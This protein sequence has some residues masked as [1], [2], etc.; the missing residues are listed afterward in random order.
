M[1][2]VSCTLKAILLLHH[3]L[4][5]SICHTLSHF[6]SSLASHT[7]HRE[8]GSG[9]ATTIEL[10]PQQKLAVTEEICAVYRSHLLSRS[11]NYV[12]TCLADVSILLSNHAF[13]NCVPWR[14]LQHDQTLPLSVKGVACKTNFF[15]HGC[16]IRLCH[17]CY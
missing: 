4:P 16:P 7:L 14:Q 12:T 9:Q 1:E 3:T 5:Y 15:C 17:Q 6:L 2:D 11:S 10:L 8:E 13:N